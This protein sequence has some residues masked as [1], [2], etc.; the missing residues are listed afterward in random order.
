MKKILALTTIFTIL[1]SGC[2]QNNSEELLS[3]SIIIKGKQYTYPIDK[4]QLKEDGFQSLITALYIKDNGQTYVLDTVS[5][6][7]EANNIIGF[8]VDNRNYTALTDLGLKEGLN[9]DSSINDFKKAYKTFLTEEIVKE[10]EN[11]ETHEMV[12]TKQLIIRNTEKENDES[13]IKVFFNEKEKV[14]KICVV[15]DVDFSEVNLEF[16]AYNESN[17]K[18]Y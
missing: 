1:L 5:Y 14:F 8:V 6:A 12:K 18:G 16:D 9:F 10:T 15:K 7:I 13:Y 3:E 2:S 4:R 11:K 17:W